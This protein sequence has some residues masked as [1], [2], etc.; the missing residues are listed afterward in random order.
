MSNSGNIKTL[1][2]LFRKYRDNTCTKEEFKVLSQLLKD[3][4]NEYEVKELMDNCLNNLPAPDL[5]A[6]SLQVEQKLNNVIHKIQRQEKAKTRKTRYF[7][8]PAFKVAASVIIILGM[9]LAIYK[10]A[11]DITHI[12]HVTKTT[13]RGQRATITLSDGSIIKLNAESAVSFE[14]KFTGDTREIALTGEAFFEVKRNPDKPFI[15]KTGELSTTVLGTSF[16]IQAYPEKDEIAVTVA[17][18]KVLVKT[19]NQK[20]TAGSQILT[21]NHQVTYHTS[22]GEM[23]K[24]KV[25]PAHFLAWKNDE[26]RLDKTTLSEAV[27]ILERWYNIEIVFANE[28]LGDCLISGKYNSDNLVNILESIKYIKGIEYRIDEDKVTLE[29]KPCN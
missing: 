2:E 24:Q 20:G 19:R 23:V 4:K 14:E 9:G 13:Q 3:G 27:V 25:D 15:V 8:K 12:H 5:T 29:G 21:P 26:I 18:G 7:S 28:A 10:T 6:E 16:N 1:N 17:T 22:S 11:S